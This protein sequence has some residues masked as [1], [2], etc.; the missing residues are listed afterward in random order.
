[1]R[2]TLTLTTVTLYDWMSCDQHAESVQFNTVEWE[3]YDGAQ[4]CLSVTFFSTL[5]NHMLPGWQASP[6][7]GY[8]A[9]NCKVEKKKKDGSK[10]SSKILFW[11]SVVRNVTIS[12]YH[13]VRGYISKSNQRR[14]GSSISNCTLLS[15]LE[16]PTKTNFNVIGP[17]FIFIF[18]LCM[19]NVGHMSA[20]LN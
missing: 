18:V 12:L 7:K 9:F 3:C 17:L 16:F 4:L 8:V 11:F 6:N 5:Q 14:N 2:A 10:L 19:Q 20:T 15:K 13:I 1:M